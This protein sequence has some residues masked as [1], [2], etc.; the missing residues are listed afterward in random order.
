[1][2]QPTYRYF[3]KI[4]NSDHISAWKSKELFDE[5]IKPLATS[6]NNL[7]PSLNYIDF[8]PRIKFHG[9]CLKQDKVIFTH[10]RVANI[11]Y[12]I[13]LWPFKESSDF[14]LVIFLLGTVKLSKNS[15]F[16]KYKYFGYGFRILARES[17]SLSDG[18]GFGKNVIIF[19]AHMISSGHAD[20][21]K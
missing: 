1:M 9:Q 6:D 3:R 18:S 17:F 13:N 21:R 2:F 19:V 8:I 4:G 14:T 15:D 20:S 5:S 11:V 10:K 16:E 12:E 7:V